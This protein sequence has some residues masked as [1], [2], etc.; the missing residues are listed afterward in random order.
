MPL[1]DQCRHLASVIRGHCACYGLTGNGKR[2]SAFRT[3]VPGSWRRR[4]GRRHRDGSIG[5][6]RFNAI[7]ARFPLPKAKV[8][9]SIHA[10]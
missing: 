4:L 8:R 2:L 5:R 9:R 3:A 6:E 10:S 1:G 7:L